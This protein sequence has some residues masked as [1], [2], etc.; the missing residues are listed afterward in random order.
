MEGDAY[1]NASF[2]Y[3]RSHLWR[4]LGILV[5]MMIGLCVVYLTA[6]EF[7]SAQRSKGEGKAN[8]PS[9]FTLKSLVLKVMKHVQEAG[10]ARRPQPQ[11]G[12]QVRFTSQ[13]NAD[14]ENY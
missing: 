8:F 11:N 13:G 7:I 1:I 3:Y 6:T 12:Y 9:F 10:S 4:N 14:S 5:A 2:A